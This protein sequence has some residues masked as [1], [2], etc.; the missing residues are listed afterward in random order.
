MAIVLLLVDAVSSG[1]AI[2]V[3]AA[4]GDGDGDGTVDSSNGAFG[5]AS[6]CIG[7]TPA[8]SRTDIGEGVVAMDRGIRRE[9]MPTGLTSASGCQASRAFGAGGAKPGGTSG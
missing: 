2:F 6:N 8:E 1:A 7:G 9:R 5:S 3:A 4:T